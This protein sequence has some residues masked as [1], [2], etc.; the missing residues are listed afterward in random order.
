MGGKS[1]KTGQVSRTLIERL[2]KGYTADLI[3]EMKSQQGCVVEKRCGEKKKKE[4]KKNATTNFSD[5]GFDLLSSVGKI[6]DKA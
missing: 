4:K 2:K 6:S 1:R 3:K 5:G